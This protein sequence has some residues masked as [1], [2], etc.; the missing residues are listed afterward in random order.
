M[1]GAFLAARGGAFDVAPRELA[2]GLVT[3][4]VFALPARALETDQFY[5]WNRPLSDATDAI[6]ERI[7]ADIGLALAR[8]NAHHEKASC[9]C[10]TAQQAIREHFDYAIIARPEL[11]ATKTSDVERIPATPDEERLFRH[12]YLY[13]GTSPFDP[14]L[15]MPPSPTIELAGV[16][17]G[18]DKLGHFFS[19]GGWLESAYRRAVG[20]GASEADALRAALQHGLSTEKTIWGMGT[21]GIL[22]LADLEANYQGL[23]F[24]RGLCD[25]PD[26]ALSLTPEGWRLARPFDFRGYVTPEWDE[27]WQ[28]NI[29]SPSRWNKVK[30]VMQR[31]C[32]RLLDPE[33]QR[34]RAGYAARDRETLTETM[35]H[36][37]VAAGKLADPRQFTI[38]SVCGATATAAP[39]GSGR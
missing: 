20:K 24:Y 33:I 13:S 1:T 32:A 18:A 21:S 4:A 14:V 25:G 34:E 9:P 27:S 6:N 11:W 38:Q 26:P 3:I 31:Y 17:V 23:L 37:W 19:D 5:A 28:P 29:Y 39:R 15:W 35:I 2:A 12:A 36:E 22:S 7:N 10:R 8:I 30:P 16:R